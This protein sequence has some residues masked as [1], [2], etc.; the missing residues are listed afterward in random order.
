MVGTATLAGVRVFF[1][2]PWPKQRHLKRRLMDDEFA[3]L[4]A[5]RL[6]DGGVLHVAT[7]MPHYAQQ[8]RGV[9]ARHPLLEPVPP[10]WRPSTKFELRG[11]VRG[12]PAA[13]PRRA[14]GA[15]VLTA[16]SPSPWPPRYRAAARAGH[17]GGAAQPGPRRPPPRGADGRGRAVRPDRVGHRGGARHGRA[18]ARERGGLPGAAGGRGGYLLWLGVQTLRSRTVP[19]LLPNGAAA[20]L[21]QR[22]AG[23]RGFG[24]GLATDLLNPKVGVFFVTFLPG[25]VPDGQPVGAASLAFGAI[26]VV[27]TAVYFALLLFLA[28]RITGW[29]R[30]TTVRRWLDRATGTVLI[31][32]GL[33]AGGRAVGRAAARRVSRGAGSPARRRGRRPA[34]PPRRTPRP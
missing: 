6:A 10:P 11:L 24:A 33:A 23:R 2:D 34:P 4:V 3:G 9:L 29:L 27:E 18:A 21:P 30:D 31:G 22:S 20:E 5:D 15:A 25:F 28:G 7:D 26:F 12:P 16:R 19:D 17:P 14:P 1:P 32:F 8:T 13:R